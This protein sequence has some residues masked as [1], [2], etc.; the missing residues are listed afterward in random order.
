MSDEDTSLTSGNESSDH[1]EGNAE[2]LGDGTNDGGASNDQGAGDA[3][4]ISAKNQPPPDKS[5][6]EDDD[7]AF[8]KALADG[9]LDSV[10][11]NGKKIAKADAETK[12]DAPP[13]EK[14][15]AEKLEEKPKDEKPAEPEK[16]LTTEDQAEIDKAP[17]AY[18]AKLKDLLTERAEIRA[19]VESVKAEAEALK[20]VK[21]FT[22][23]LIKHATDAGLVKVVDGKIDTTDLQAYIEEARLVR[24]STPKQV[25]EYF[26]RLAHAAYP[27]GKPVAIPADL[28]ELVELGSIPAEE[29]ETIARQREAKAVQPQEEA[30]RQREAAAAQEAERTRAAQTAAAETARKA[31]IEEM[32]QV[33]TPY[34]TRFGAEWASI[35]KDVKAELLPLLGDTNPTGWGK[36]AK[37]VIEAVVARRRAV[38]TKKPPTSPPPTTAPTAKKGR[39]MSE[40]EEQKALASGTL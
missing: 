16:V 6:P 27:E 31:G 38:P 36:L 28:K 18:R 12:A 25:Y 29:A 8:I 39:V 11:A 34:Q 7:A 32:N 22:D 5:T 40:E 3:D 10:D 1:V 30:R 33:A 4:G 21:Q 9:D 17:K 23:N 24:T 20:P 26:T 2:P 13:E 15:P 35:E 19:T 37:T 14:P